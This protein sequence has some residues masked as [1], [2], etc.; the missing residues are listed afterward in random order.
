MC[1]AQAS[2]GPWDLI[3]P[4]PCG[5]SDGFIPILQ[6][7]KLNLGD[8]RELAQVYILSAWCEWSP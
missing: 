6:I 8:V 3:L 1:Q 2:P 4:I 5:V 7:G